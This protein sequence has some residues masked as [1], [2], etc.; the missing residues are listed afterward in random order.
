M[1]TVESELHENAPTT[2]LPPRRVSENA[3]SVAD[4]SIASE[5]DTTT[6]ESRLTPVASSLGDTDDTV[7][8]VRAVSKLQLF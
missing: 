2:A 3:A 5:N 1:S 6:F 4:W 8:A 7:G